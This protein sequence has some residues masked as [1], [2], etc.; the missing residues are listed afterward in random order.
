MINTILIVVFYLVSQMTLMWLWYK[1]INNPS[2]VDLSW[3]IGLMMAGLIYL[4]ADGIN[5]RKL[6]IAA[7]LCVWAIRLAGHLWWTRLRFGH[8]DKR[9]TAIS[10]DWKINP[11]VGFFINFQIQAFLIFLISFIF[12]FI[13]LSPAMTLSDLDVI[14]VIIIVLAISGETI[15]DMQLKKFKETHIKQVCN[16]G[17]WRYSRHP[18]YFFDWLSWAGFTLFAMQS[19]MGCFSLISLMVLYIIFTRITGPITE[20]ESIQS[21]GQAYL[22]Y[23][24]KT[25]MFIPWFNYRDK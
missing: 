19:T 14:A 13:S 3:S 6:V 21:R 2:I 7:L 15:A 12:F 20:R 18:N 8:I 25:S 4:F 9:Y 22:D 5:H 16:V 17:L 23:Q 10:K 24:A 1:R 11:A